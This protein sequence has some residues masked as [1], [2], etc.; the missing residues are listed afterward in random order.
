MEKGEGKSTMMITNQS[1]AGE[2]EGREARARELQNSVR[3][4]PQIYSQGRLAARSLQQI[5]SL[6]ARQTRPF[7]HV[8][9]TSP[10]EVSLYHRVICTKACKR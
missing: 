7:A 3:E 9:S 5:I 8:W 1:S 4:K 10:L 6:S 2:K